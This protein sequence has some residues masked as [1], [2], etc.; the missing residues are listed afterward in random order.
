[1]TAVPF[2]RFRAFIDAFDAFLVTS[3]VDP[4]GDA[5]GSCLG[6]YHA[7][8][9][10]G[11]EAVVALDSPLPAN[12]RFLPGAEEVRPAAPPERRLP[13]AWVLDCSSLDRAGRVPELF[14][15]PRAR[16]ANV[17]HH[18]GND[19][20]GDPRLVGPEASAT[21][22][23]VYDI[24]DAYGSPLR[25][26]TAEC[27]YAGIL[28]DTGGFRFQNTTPRS[29][30][31]AARLAEHGASAP[32][33]AEELYMKRSAGSLRILGLALASLEE[34]S[35]GQIGA[36]TITRKMFRQAGAEPDEADGIVQFAKALDGTR[37]GVLIQEIE[38]DE[39]RASL[40]SDGTVDVNAVAGRF[41]GGGHRTAAGLR[42]RGKLEE[43]RRNLL[44]AIEQAVNGGP[45]S[46]R[47]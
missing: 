11:K 47:G 38:P 26:E 25:P 42:V 7:L 9:G 30:R 10:M 5:V 22:E 33:I 39:I 23:L 34:R 19:G 36:L 3:H 41:G 4:D 45:P 16:V 29:L 24:L 31:L 12:L 21:A 8:R 14:L 6:L 40:R 18:V 15:L 20:F 37:V 1:V 2:D 44:E 27:L 35:G 28:S 17:D 43:V 46:S 32:A 13:A